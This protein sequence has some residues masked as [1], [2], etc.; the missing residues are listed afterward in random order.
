V[1]IKRKRITQ[2]GSGAYAIYLPKKWI[3][4]WSREQRAR[5][6]VDLHLINNSLLIV[7][8]LRRRRF[9]ARVRADAE[10]VRTML[11]SS[12]VRGHHEATLRPAGDQPFSEACVAMARSFLRHLDER[13]LTTVRPHEISFVVPDNAP[14]AYATGDALLRLM[15]TKLQEMVT[16]AAECVESFGTRPEG[17][18]HAAQLLASMQEEDLARLYRQALRMVANLELPLGTASEFQVLDLV[19]AELESMGASCLAVA[20]VVVAAHGIAP[21]DLHGPRAE[22]GRRMEPLADLPTALTTVLRVYARAFEQAHAI[23]GRLGAALQG[24][25][26]EDLLQVMR[27]ARAAATELSTRL[28]AT[29]QELLRGGQLSAPAYIVYQVRQPASSL[30]FGLERAAERAVSLTAAQETAPA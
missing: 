3:D 22:L 1:A 6:E 2:V 23:L 20:H 17:A 12:Y 18:L 27:D 28:Y 19:A 29:V 7:P 15:V 9:E 24:R 8:V 4:A 30:L 11:L 21:A 14:P 26:T 25:G 13:L 10:H 5:R 16:L